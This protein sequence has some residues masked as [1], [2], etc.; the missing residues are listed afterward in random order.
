MRRPVISDPLHVLPRGPWPQVHEALGRHGNAV[1]HTT[2][3]AWLPATVTERRLRR[4]LGRG[5]W[6]RWRRI[7]DP[8]VRHRFAASRLLMKF[9]AAAALDTRPELLEVAYGLG[10]R[11]F[12][13]GFDQIDLSLTHTGEFMAV[14]LSKDG[15]IGV[16]AE[17]ADRRMNVEVLHTQMCTPAEVAAMTGLSPDERAARTLRLWTLKEAY[18]KALGQGRRL[19]FTEFGFTA[20]GDRLLAADGAA[21]DHAAWGFATHHVL[22][23][24]LLS[25]AC[26]DEG[27][28]ADHDV[29]ARSTLD[30]GFAAA[31]AHFSN[32]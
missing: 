18:T 23:R 11:P 1:V 9:T 14:G 20:D 7:P 24:Y 28:D 4:I 16:D 13:R 6:L 17:P 5:D 12:L 27:L 30:P 29:S 21:P 22:G 26:H 32:P 3:G 10:G 2:W 15:R 25:T 19:R 31:M 8:T